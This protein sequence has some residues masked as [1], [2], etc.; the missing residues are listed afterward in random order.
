MGGAKLPRWHK[1][2]VHATSAG[3]Y[4]QSLVQGRRPSGG[5]PDSTLGRFW[6]AARIGKT[7]RDTGVGQVPLGATLRNA[8]PWAIFSPST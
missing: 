3:F 4:I 5:V 1:A 7:A 2:S 8:L 6:Y